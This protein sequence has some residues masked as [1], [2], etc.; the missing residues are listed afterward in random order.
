MPPAEVKRRPP[1]WVNVARTFTTV[2]GSH[3][4]Y[5]VVFD[6]PQTYSDGDGPFIA[7]EVQATGL[8]PVESATGATIKRSE[9][10]APG[11]LL[12]SWFENPKLGY[13][14]QFKAKRKAR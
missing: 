8:S 7:A 9:Y 13:R 11:E 3:T 2:K 14:A 12:F 6:E 10:F 4:T 1:E 5:W